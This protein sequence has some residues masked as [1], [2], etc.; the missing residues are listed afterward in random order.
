MGDQ[1]GIKMRCFLDQKAAFIFNF[2]ITFKDS[3]KHRNRKI[4]LLI[5]TQ[6]Y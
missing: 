3:S 5:L 6:N 1:K 4:Y 2:I